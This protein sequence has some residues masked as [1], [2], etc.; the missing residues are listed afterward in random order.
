MS[1]VR[2]GN[3]HGKRAHSVARQPGQVLGNGGAHGADG[4]AH[5]PWVA[6]RQLQAHVPGAG[7]PEPTVTRTLAPDSPTAM[8]AD[9][10]SLRNVP[11]APSDRMLDDLAQHRKKITARRGRNIA[12]V[13]VAVRMLALV[14]ICLRVGHIRALTQQTARPHPAGGRHDLRQRWSAW[15]LRSLA[16][17]SWRRAEGL[18]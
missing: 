8:P 1:P 11:G 16:R 15:S 17:D 7:S 4:A 10:R 5:R 18:I 9:R 12:A 3:G 14:Y 6:Q 2:D 13:A